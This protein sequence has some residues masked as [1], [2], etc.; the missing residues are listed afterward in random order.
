[1]VNKKK[2]K[3]KEKKKKNYPAPTQSV[4]ERA[5]QASSLQPPDQN[6]HKMDN[7]RKIDFFRSPWRSDRSSIKEVL[8]KEKRH[9]RPKKPQNKFKF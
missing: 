6:P 3:K 7:E 9:N 4:D 1:M 2:K 5:K 8:S